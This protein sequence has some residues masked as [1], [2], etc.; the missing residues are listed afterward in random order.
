[1]DNQGTVKD[2]TFVGRELKN[3]ELGG[4]ITVAINEPSLGFIQNVNLLPDTIINGG[5]LTGQIRG[6]ANGKAKLNRAKLRNAKLS[7]VIIGADCELAENVIFGE[8]VRFADNAIIPEQTDLTEALSTDDGIDITTDVVTDGPSLLSQIN[9]LPDM[10]ANEWKL[11]QN[12]ESGKLE[13]VV[14]GIRLV[15]IPKQV[16]QAKR[17]RKGQINIHD[18]G[19]VTVITAQGREIVVEIN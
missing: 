9:D 1:L 18:D 8:G 12:Q 6:P 3:G 5:Q 15:I 4:T 13:V 11:I 2:I 16:K 17:N 7:N 19:T 14:D 10:Q